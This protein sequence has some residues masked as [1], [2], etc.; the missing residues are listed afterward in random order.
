MTD[1]PP[2][3]S[4]DERA[5]PLGGRV[6]V[7]TGGGRGVGRAIVRALARAGA[8]V[9]A[10]ARTEAELAAT[11]ALV[12]ADGGAAHARPVDVT[13]RAA[14]EALV[15]GAVSEFGAVDVLV[16]NAGSFAALGPVWAVEPEAWLR[17][18]T[19]NL[20]GP[21]LCARAVLPHMRARRR[22]VIL[23]LAGGGAIGAAPNFTGYGSSKAGIL[24][25]TESLAKEVAPDGVFVYA[26]NPGLVRTAMTEAL[27]AHPEVGTYN[28]GFVARMAGGH[29]VP[30][31]RA[32][33]LA[34]FL[35]G[36]RDPRLSG[37]LF[38]VN[39]DYASLPERA[40]T[41]AR[42]DLQL[43]RLRR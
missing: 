9:L 24:R 20:Y 28:A 7:V 33:D 26:L 12:A 38:D 15:A 18:V 5:R 31:E 39:W 37:R 4:S 32:G 3:V 22:G 1:Q 17:D 13:D 35:A 21:F 11:V 41:I 10:A 16:N 6:A 23:N 25:F 29:D 14:V 8:V 19:T 36:L 27:L 42:D 30:P 2:A 43:L 40:E 34:V